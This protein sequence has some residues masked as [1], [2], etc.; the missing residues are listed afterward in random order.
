MQRII[1]D[2]DC[3]RPFTFVYEPIESQS[4]GRRNSVNV[5]YLLCAAP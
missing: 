4:A 2:L 3:S 5:T 1:S